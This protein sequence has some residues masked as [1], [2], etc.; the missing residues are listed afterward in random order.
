MS[1]SSHCVVR[2][3]SKQWWLGQNSKK[4]YLR[5]AMKFGYRTNEALQAFTSLCIDTEITFC[6]IIFP[7]YYPFNSLQYTARYFPSYSSIHKSLC[8]RFHAYQLT[9]S[10]DS[11]ARSDNNFIIQL[12]W[13]LSLHSKANWRL[14]CIGAYNSPV[15]SDLPV[16]LIIIKLKSILNL[17]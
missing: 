17:Y 4:A 3:S 9:R 14:F 10:S 16:K 15:F 5:R 6:W 11:L 1:Q 8:N 12:L 7:K 13:T 2:T